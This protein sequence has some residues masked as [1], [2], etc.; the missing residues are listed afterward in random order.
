MRRAIET[1]PSRSSSFTVPISRRYMRTGSFVFSTAAGSETTVPDP[2]T[3]EKTN[4]PVRMYLRE[5]GTV[6]L[7][8]R[9]GEVS[10]A[11]RIENGEAKIYR[12]LSTNK[13]VLGEILKIVEQAKKDK[14][15]ARGFLEFAAAALEETD[16]IDPR[17][18]NRIGSI[19]KHFE[20]IGKL[21][22]EL[23]K[24]AD[25]K[26]PPPKP[27]KLTVKALVHAKA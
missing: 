2:A 21:D 26:R 11:R 25:R 15:V 5:M 16:E 3:V 7:L 20:K 9:A 13:V 27:K 4:D 22:G 18:A 23:R 12:A 6:K 17:T 19:Q 14:N 1:S 24:L 10:I 8:D